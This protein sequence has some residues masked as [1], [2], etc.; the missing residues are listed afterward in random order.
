[1]DLDLCIAYQMPF[2]QGGFSDARIGTDLH[3]HSPRELH[4]LGEEL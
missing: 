3:S 1:M 4:V 2:P